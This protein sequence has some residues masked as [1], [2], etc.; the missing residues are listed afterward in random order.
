[1]PVKAATKTII[2]T[3]VFLADTE[4]CELELDGEAYG[5]AGGFFMF[6]ESAKENFITVALSRSLAGNA[7]H[8]VFV[9][10]KPSFRFPPGSPESASDKMTRRT[11]QLLLSL[12]CQRL[13]AALLST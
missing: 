8:S 12:S 7:R 3:D 10:C 4:S 6:I 13:A 1:M 2:R 9:R 11:T 5:F